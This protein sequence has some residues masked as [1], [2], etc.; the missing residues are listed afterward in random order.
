METSGKEK[1][2]EKQEDGKEEELEEKET[3][4]DEVDEDEND[5]GEKEK[6]FT[7]EEVNKMMAREKR[8]GAA[9]VYR[10][11][12]IKSS[13]TKM[14]NALKAFINSQKTDDQKAEADN[15]ALK[16][17]NRKLLIAEAKAEAMQ[18]GVQAQYVDDVVTLAIGKKTDDEEFDIKTAISELKTKY[19]VW[20]TASKDDDK[21][22]Q[23]VGQKGTGSSVKSG[24]K[25]KTDGK[26]SLGKRLAAN[27]RKSL[28]SS[29]SYWSTK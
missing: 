3:G 16:E 14:L 21:K 23:D 18:L 7:Q 5:E 4:A 20:F 15:E 28:G 6:T 19:P 1:D 27:R 9:S 26:E 8:Q 13:D 25:D 29:K 17:A 12:G 10:L 2:I 24:R 22:K 11:L